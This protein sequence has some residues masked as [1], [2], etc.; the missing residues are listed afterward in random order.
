MRKEPKRRFNASVGSIIA[1]LFLFSLSILFL[2][3]FVWMLSTSLKDLTELGSSSWVPQRLAW[4]NYRTAFSFGQWV[5]WLFYKV[6]I[7]FVSVMG[8]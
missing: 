2:V 5:R 7:T 3:P 4:D 6:L 8:S 1:W